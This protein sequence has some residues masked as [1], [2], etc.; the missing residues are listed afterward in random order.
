[1]RVGRWVAGVL[2]AGAAGVVV[3]LPWAFG[4]PEAPLPEEGLSPALASLTSPEYDPR[5]GLAYWT[6][7]FAGG[8]EGEALR[9]VGFCRGVD[10]D[11]RPNCRTVLVLEQAARMPGFFGE[12]P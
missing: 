11:R 8:L 2:L 12:A 3:L 5:F 9:A 6:S 10:L 1:M 7:R 4:R